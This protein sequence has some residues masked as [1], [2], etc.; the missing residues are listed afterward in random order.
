MR[1]HGSVTEEVG[2]RGEFLSLNGWIGTA[3]EVNAYWFLTAGRAFYAPTEGPIQ[4]PGSLL[5]GSSIERKKP[6]ASLVKFRRPSLI[7]L[8]N[9]YTGA[10]PQL[11]YC[12]Q[13]LIL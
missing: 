7:Y 4:V 2:E 13:V 3:I 5:F 1:V 10:S 12:M 11:I 9:V 6:L 8:P